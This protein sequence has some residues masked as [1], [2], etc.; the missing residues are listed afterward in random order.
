M[1]LMPP[2]IS[3]EGKMKPRRLARETRVSISFSGSATLRCA[4]MVKGDTSAVPDCGSGGASDSTGEVDR[5]HLPV[6]VVLAL[7]LECAFGEHQVALVLTEHKDS[8]P[9]ARA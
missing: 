6:Q 9:R 4:G 3:L 8:G 5:F 2:Y 1:A 7:G